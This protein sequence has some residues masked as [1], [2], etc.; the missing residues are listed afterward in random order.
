M[1]IS[2][3]QAEYEQ[4]SGSEGIGP[5]SRHTGTGKI[6]DDSQRDP[7]LRHSLRGPHREPSLEND[8][9]AGFVPV[10]LT[11]E[12]GGLSVELTSADMLIGRHSEADIRL[13]L[14]DISRRHCRCFFSDG[15]WQVRD[16][17]SLNG[18]FVNGQRMHE[19]TLYDGDRLQLGSLVFSVAIPDRPAVVPMPPRQAEVLQHIGEALRQTVAEPKR[20]AS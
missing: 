16:L 8:F 9:P 4:S 11:L 10:R 19:A 18:V 2:L 5:S 6:M 14:P 13:A 15:H 1:A 7:A 12:P 3:V 20:K 17:N